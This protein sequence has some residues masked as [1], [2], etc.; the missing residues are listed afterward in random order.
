MLR[1]I[2][3][4]SKRLEA[5]LLA[6]HLNLYEP[7]RRHITNILDALLVC[8]EKKSLSALHRQ[9]VNPPS[10]V[11]ALCDCFRDSPWEGAY[12]RQQAQP[13]LVQQLVT[14]ARS[15]RRRAGHL[16]EWRRFVDG[17]R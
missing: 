12:L 4:N 15:P 16:S 9:L 13:Y 10:D 11:Y 17:E 8:D 2:F 6:L 5:F 1:Q 7:Q 14:Q 3:K